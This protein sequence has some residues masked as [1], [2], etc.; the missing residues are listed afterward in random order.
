MDRT[1]VSWH[2]FEEVH[3]FSP[4]NCI[5][6][7]SNKGE[8]ANFAC[9]LLYVYPLR[10]WRLLRSP[11]ADRPWNLNWIIL[12]GLALHEWLKRS[13]HWLKMLILCGKL[14][15]PHSNW[16]LAG[17]CK[18]PCESYIV[19]NLVLSRELKK[20]NFPYRVLDCL[21]DRR[22]QTMHCF[23]LVQMVREINSRLVKPWTISKNGWISS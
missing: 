15:Q 12:T 21:L 18:T 16:K 9:H 5:E 4:W 2:G 13:I 22:L 10:A 3:G 8:W 19:I 23:V 7:T 1:W 11:L 14:F 17:L 20:W 6:S